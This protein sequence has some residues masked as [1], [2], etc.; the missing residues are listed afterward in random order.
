MGGIGAVA[1]PLVVIILLFGGTWIN[2]N[3]NPGRKR[4]RPGEVRAS[5]SDANLQDMEEEGLVVRSRS[6][7]P[8]LLPEQQTKF[9]RRT[10]GI[11]GWK[12]DV[13]TPNTKRF[14]A[15]LLSRLLERFPF[16]VECWYWGLIYWVGLHLVESYKY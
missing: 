10:I 15:N 11:W 1:E 4:C 8:N 7:S 3:V 12:R 2:R 5:S 13:S 14:K 16:L 9:R 6:N